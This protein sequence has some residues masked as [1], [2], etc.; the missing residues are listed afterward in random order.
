MKLLQKIFQSISILCQDTDYKQLYF[1]FIII[2]QQSCLWTS[3]TEQI[4]TNPM[5]WILTRMKLWW[6]A[7]SIRRVRH[8]LEVIQPWLAALSV[9]VLSILVQFPFTTA[10]P[11]YLNRWS[12]IFLFSWNYSSPVHADFRNSDFQN[13][14][15]ARIWNA[16]L[17]IRNNHSLPVQI[18]WVK[19][20]HHSQSA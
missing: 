18:Q 10:M 11:L 19:P 8:S 14:E 17:Q 16:G 1:S 3:N 20:L 15:Q 6:S 5:K 4:R 9:L 7:V 13:W 12:V 2:K